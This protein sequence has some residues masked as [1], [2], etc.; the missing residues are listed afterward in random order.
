MCCSG[1]RP[2]PIGC[3][4]GPCYVGIGGIKLPSIHRVSTGTAHNAICEIHDATLGRTVAHRDRIGLVC[5]GMRPQGKAPRFSGFGAIAQRDA[6]VLST[7]STTD[8]HCTGV[9]VGT[10]IRV[11][12]NG[13]LRDTRSFCCPRATADGNRVLGI[14]LGIV[15]KGGSPN[16]ITTGIGTKHRH[17][18][19]RALRPIAED[20]IPVA[21]RGRSM[22][23]AGGV[24]TIGPCRG[25]EG[26]EK[27]TATS[28]GWKGAVVFVTNHRQAVCS[29]SS[30]ADED[31]VEKSGMGTGHTHGSGCC[32]YR[33]GQ[34]TLTRMSDGSRR[35]GC[36]A[37]VAGDLTGYHPALLGAAPQ[38]TIDTIHWISL[39][40][41]SERTPPAPLAGLR[42]QPALGARVCR[43]SR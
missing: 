33:N 20:S 4:L 1:C 35:T 41:M 32:R 42:N 24:A 18:P 36:A 14:C 13:N 10:C 15:T 19:L 29:R 8:G 2:R 38:T 6:V 39:T 3:C 9:A 17:V 5:N 37:L 28:V 12:T 30:A 11:A 43:C 7:G 21:H 27:F 40:G 25:T 23:V 22:T 26:Q 31:I 16:A 34:R